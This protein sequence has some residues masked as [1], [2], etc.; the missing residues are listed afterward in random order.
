[1]IQEEAQAW[2]AERGW[3][4]GVAGDRLSRLAQLV[5]EENA[6][7]NL[8]AASTVSLIWSRHIVD[9][10]QLLGLA[11]SRNGLWIDLGSGGGFPGLV[12]AC[13]RDDP[14]VLVETRGLRAN[15]LNECIADLELSHATVV[16]SK[17][18]QYRI[19]HPAAVIS[20]RAFAPL[21]RTLEIG[22]HLSGQNTLWLLPKG[23]SAQLELESA[24]QEWQ[25]VFHVEQSVTDPASAIIIASGVRHRES[26]TGRIARSR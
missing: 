25:A 4:T 22:I 3:M 24:R 8:V 19:S 6:H 5:V 18:E 11:Q 1:M 9:S 14:I 23:Q 10:A 26:A 2:L 17:V 7:Q 13:L 20:A 21:V 15:F 12:V 16:K